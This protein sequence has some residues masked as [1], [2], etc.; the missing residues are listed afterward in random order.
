MKESRDEIPDSFERKLPRPHTR[1]LSD[2][3][4]ELFSDEDAPNAIKQMFGYLWDNK[5]V[6]DAFSNNFLVNYCEDKLKEDP[7]K[8]DQMLDLVVHRLFTDLTEET[9]DQ[10]VILII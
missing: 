6:F 5:D 9:P 8:V 2:E 1:I 10:R 3:P 4:T 7:F